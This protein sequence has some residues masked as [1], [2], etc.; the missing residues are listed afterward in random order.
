[1]RLIVGIDPGTTTGVAVLDVSSDFYHVLSKKHASVSDISWVVVEYGNPIS[2]A[3]DVPKVPSL[4]KKLA[5]VFDC[6]VY[7]PKKTVSVGEKKDMTGG[8]E[9]ANAH[10]RDA[11]AAGLMAKSHF[12]SIFRRVERT[13]R[14]KGLEAIIDDIKE[15]VVKRE[16]PNIEQAIQ[17]LVKK[18]PKKRKII[19][20]RVVDTKRILKLRER[21]EALEKEKSILKNQVASLK[22]QIQKLKTSRKAPKRTLGS[23]IECLQREKNLLLRRLENLKK[24]KELE[25]EYEIIV[26][27]EEKN[28]KNKIVL[29]ENDADVSEIEKHRPKA[30]IAKIPLRAKVPVIRFQDIN[31]EK[32]GKFLVVKKNDLQKELNKPERFLSWLKKYKERYNEKKK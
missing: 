23:K 13:A 25:K 24:E 32:K 29:V 11:L 14:E 6:P 7:A 19:V 12:S 3:C 30:I 1:M 8:F 28:L 18:E 31:V 10:E 16:V 17:L 9:Y 4:V 5:S 21:I 15:L 22:R 2:I 26:R 20:S 27:P